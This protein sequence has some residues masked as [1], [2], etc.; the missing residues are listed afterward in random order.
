M[1]LGVFEVIAA[2][3]QAEIVSYSA[4]ISSCAN[5]GQW[6][7]SLFLFYQMLKAHISPN[8]I[9]CNAAISSCEKA[10]QWQL[11]LNFFECILVMQLCMDVV[12]FNSLLISC[13][14]CWQWPKALRLFDAMP[15]HRIVPNLLSYSV[16][17]SCGEKAVMQHQKI[18]EHCEILQSRMLKEIRSFGRLEEQKKS[19]L[20][21][22]Q[23]LASC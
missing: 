12:T 10:R 19:K 23:V 20:S 5:L 7:H 21:K 8:I 13:D 16:A 1:G 18:H 9:T 15:E 3:G 17:I 4:A 6:Q 22:I 11:A 14:R 2:S